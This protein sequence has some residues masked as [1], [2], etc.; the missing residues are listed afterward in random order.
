MGI[1][2]VLRTLGYTTSET[3]PLA[4]QIYAESGTTLLVFV[5]GY[6]KGVMK[7]L[8]ED[9]EIKLNDQALKKLVTQSVIASNFVSML[10]AL[11]NTGIP[12]EALE[13]VIWDVLTFI[14]EKQGERKDSKPPRGDMN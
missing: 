8:R 10:T 2:N 5:D 4:T 3:E 9:K 14:K 7:N 1:A 11:A 6:I 12:D 13:R